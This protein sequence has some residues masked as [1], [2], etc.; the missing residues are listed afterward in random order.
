MMN[1]KFID[2]CQN[3]NFDFINYD[4]LNKDEIIYA[5][6]CAFTL[7]NKKH[8]MII[9]N[10]VKE[11]K[12]KLPGYFYCFATFDEK[13]IKF[14]DKNNLC[15]YDSRD[16]IRSLDEACFRG[17][18][19]IIKYLLN[20]YPFSTYHFEQALLQPIPYKSFIKATECFISKGYDIH[21]TGTVVFDLTQNV[22]LKKAKYVVNKL[23]KINE[24]KKLS[25]F[26]ALY[27]I[28]V[29]QYDAF[30]KFFNEEYKNEL[31]PFMILNG[32]RMPDV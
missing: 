1:T 13:I 8:I 17:K 10:K 26:F 2:D 3:N 32:W 12:I 27:F 31:L 9:L 15:N 30:I 28:M 6:N 18:V 23:I 29:K 22:D 4:N 21:N 7:K 5:L 11:I 24:D 25:F 19:N 20:K 16:I 14:L